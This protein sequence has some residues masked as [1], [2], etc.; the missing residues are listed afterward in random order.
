MPITVLGNNFTIQ[1]EK[2][3]KNHWKKKTMSLDAIHIGLRRMYLNN[4][5]EV[6][7]WVGA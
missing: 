7:V 6:S 1:Y 2:K 4:A 3:L 5:Q